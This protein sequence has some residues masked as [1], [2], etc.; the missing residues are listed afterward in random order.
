MKR[1]I[2]NIVE[3]KSFDSFIIF[4]VMIF[5]LLVFAFFILDVRD[6]DDN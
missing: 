6:Y 5:L 1:K 3:S 4:L 2:A